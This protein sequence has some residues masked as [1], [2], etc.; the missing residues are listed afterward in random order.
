MS[1]NKNPDLL[2]DVAS[3]EA[4]H[5]IWRSPSNL[6]IIKYWGKY[7]NQLPQNPSISFTLANS[8]TE[9]ALEY[10]AKATEEAG[11]DLIMFFNGEEDEKITAKTRDFLQSMLEYF[12]FLEQLSLRIQTGNSFPHSAGIASSA[13][14]MSALA[15]CLCSLEDRFFGTL[16]EPEAF[17]QKASFIARLG[18]GS[19]C[20]SVFPYMS[21]WGAYEGVA[22]SSNEYAIPMEDEIHEVFKGYHNAI[23]IVSSEEK[24][25][26]SRAGHALMEDNPYAAPRY[27]QANDRMKRLLEILKEGDVHA[28][29][30][31]AEEEALTLHALMMASSPSYTL[32]R[33]NTLL[34]IERIRAYREETGHPVY[35]SLDA[36]PN[37]HLLYPDSVKE[38]VQLLIDKQLIPLCEKGFWIK[39]WIG[40]GPEEI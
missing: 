18:S 20:R 8:F 32:L 11:I 36:G 37:I 22:G 1:L 2:L 30:V 25:V 6:A 19:A 26:S 29:G 40:E 34:M 24:S 9:T 4:G 28:F 7:G 31:I 21:L 38:E 12:P 14:G 27:Q 17:D 16:S 10:K 33:P 13:S 3:I 35:F 23:M 5:I 39:D 15:L